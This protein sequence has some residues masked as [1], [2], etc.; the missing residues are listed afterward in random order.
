[1]KKTTLALCLLL[2]LPLFSQKKVLDIAFDKIVS[3]YSLGEYGTALLEVP[4]NGA[5]R[6]NY[7][8]AD[9]K[10]SWQTKRRGGRFDDFKGFLPDKNGL[11]FYGEYVSDM[12]SNKTCAYVRYDYAGN[13][14]E[15]DKQ[16]YQHKMVGCVSFGGKAW[17]LLEDEPN[18]G[19]ASKLYLQVIDPVNLKPLGEPQK[20]GLPERVSKSDLKYRSGAIKGTVASYWSLAGHNEKHLL[21]YGKRTDTEKGQVV[22]EFV[23]TDFSGEQ[24]GTFNVEILLKDGKFI[25]R[26]NCVPNINEK[27]EHYSSDPA[28]VGGINLAGENID[29]GLFGGCH[30]DLARDAIYFYGGYGNEPDDGKTKIVGYFLQKFTLSGENIWRYQTKDDVSDPKAPY[31]YRRPMYI[32]PNT[33]N[34]RVYFSNFPGHILSVDSMG[35]NP[36]LIAAP[37]YNFKNVN[38]LTQ[39]KQMDTHWS[40]DLYSMYH[41]EAMTPNLLTSYFGSSAGTSLQTHL[42]KNGSSTSVYLIQKFARGFRVVEINPAQKQNIAWELPLKN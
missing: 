39:E 11:T 17:F 30:V 2:S 37:A 34:G 9:G 5:I 8:S 29:W 21:F 15:R 32:T 3:T 33:L 23:K 22:Y 10:V 25:H 12:R 40:P 18:L 20:I 41:S 36:E 28:T 14:I 27:W 13:V 35:A 1:M 16:K 6:I 24:V 38:V 26:T 4:N 7:I 19:G 31:A 42:E